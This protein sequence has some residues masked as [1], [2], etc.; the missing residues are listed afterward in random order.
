MKI[1]DEKFKNNLLRYVFQCFLATVTISAVLMFL[2]VIT[3][4]A[5]IAALGASTFIIFTMPNSYS[6]D[7]RRLIGGYFVGISVGMFFSILLELNVYLINFSNDI[8]QL[9]IFGAISVGIL[10]FIMTI[11]N[12]EHAPAA[13]ISLGLVINPWSLETIIF[14]IVAIVWL[15][16]IKRILQPYLID[17]RSNIE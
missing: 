3:E 8:N 6:S 7:P 1:L 11:T 2:N 9:V 4:T 16:K 10:I 13:C 5:I 14:I 17:L 15:Y 12:T